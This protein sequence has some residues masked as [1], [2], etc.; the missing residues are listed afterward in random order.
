MNGSPLPAKRDEPPSPVPP[1]AVLMAHGQWLMA[2]GWLAPPREAD[3]DRRAAGSQAAF[4]EL[5]A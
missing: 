5:K 1:S 3:S 4:A 2:H